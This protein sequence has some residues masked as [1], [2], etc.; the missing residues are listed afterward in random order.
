MKL[1][2]TLYFRAFVTCKF[3][4]HTHIKRD[5]EKT[6]QGKEAEG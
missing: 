3:E 6:Y 4:Y 1:L 2:K 5:T